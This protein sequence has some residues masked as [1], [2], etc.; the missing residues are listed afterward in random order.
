VVVGDENPHARIVVA[1]PVVSEV[2]TS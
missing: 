2:A 1:E